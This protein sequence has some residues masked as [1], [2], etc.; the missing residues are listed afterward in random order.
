MSDSEGQA[1]ERSIDEI[2]RE[3]RE[4]IDGLL[5]QAKELEATADSASNP[6]IAARLYSQAT[7]LRVRAICLNEPTLRTV[8]EEV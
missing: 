6:E 1:K 2:Q 8:E 4:A 3:R 5:S 7:N